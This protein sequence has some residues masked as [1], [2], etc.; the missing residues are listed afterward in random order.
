MKIEELSNILLEQGIHGAHAPKAKK[1]SK[2]KHAEIKDLKTK[3][4]E[5][6]LENECLKQ[7]VA[8][9]TTR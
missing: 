2:D 9:L 5:L 8:F 4:V 3:T 7:T 1:N 6:S